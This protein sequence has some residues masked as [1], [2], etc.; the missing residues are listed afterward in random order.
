M[1]LVRLLDAGESGTTLGKFLEVLMRKFE[2][3]TLLLNLSRS[4]M[5]SNYRKF[6]QWSKRTKRELITQLSK[7][8]KVCQ[9]SGLS[10][11]KSVRGTIARIKANDKKFLDSLGDKLSA[12][13]N[14]IVNQIEDLRYLEIAAQ[15]IQFM[16][17]A[18]PLFGPNVHDKFPQSRYDIRE[19]GK[20]IALDRST[21]AVMHLMRALEPA[22][23]RMAAKVNYFPDRNVWGG[24]I[25]EIQDRLD[26][27]NTAK[28]IGVKKIR[29][30]LAP[31]AVQFR[32]FKDAWRDHAM[33]SREKY[34]IDEAHTVFHGVK[35]FMI[36]I[37]KRV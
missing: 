9:N 5:Q 32:H 27:K 12:M 10:A 28:Y 4:E 16:E 22:L 35:S 11:A 6:G 15:D 30:R 34:T 23:M 14:E 29:E 36:Y 1:R 21:A 8:E 25:D 37:A 26:P 17:P 2:L 7:V 33:H 13:R 24:I 31:A 18:E 3:P 20:C 19:A